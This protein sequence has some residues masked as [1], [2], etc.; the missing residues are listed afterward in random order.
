MSKIIAEAYNCRRTRCWSATQGFY[1]SLIKLHESS[2][3]FSLME[4]V[5]TLCITEYFLFAH[6]WFQ[7]VPIILV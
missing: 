1:R 4:V 5:A 7:K 6:F 3:K 2:Y